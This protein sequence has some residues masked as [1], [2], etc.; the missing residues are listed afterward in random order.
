MVR[1]YRVWVA[2]GAYS[3]TT[4]GHGQSK[5][6]PLIFWSEAP[7]DIFVGACDAILPLSA[8]ARLSFARRSSKPRFSARI[9]SEQHCADLFVKRPQFIDGQ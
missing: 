3:A 1:A 9:F 4:L 6:V 2:T 7:E 8:M 5:K